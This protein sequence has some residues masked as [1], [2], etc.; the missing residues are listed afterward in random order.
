MLFRFF[1]LAAALLVAGCISAPNPDAPADI[2]A[3]LAEIKDN[4]GMIIASLPS[5]GGNLYVRRMEEGELVSTKIHGGGNSAGYDFD[6][7]YVLDS[8]RYGIVG[9]GYPGGTSYHFH[10][11][12]FTRDLDKL[13]QTLNAS[14][15]TVEAGEIKHIGFIEV[16]EVPAAYN[17][18][19][20]GSRYRMAIRDLTEEEKARVRRR[21]PTI[22]DRIKFEKAKDSVLSEIVCKLKPADDKARADAAAKTGNVRSKPGDLKPLPPRDAKAE[23]LIA[24]MCSSR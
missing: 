2:S 9:Y 8:G 16:V 5:P 12:F 13:K 22:S 17:W 7:V 6:P 18:F 15:F 1:P 4:R 20:G 19:K 23:A 14:R 10:S 24:Q 11:G 21:Y 3:K